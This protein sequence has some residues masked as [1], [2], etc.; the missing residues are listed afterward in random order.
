MAKTSN[1][2]KQKLQSILRERGLGQYANFVV[3]D[4][5][6]NIHAPLWAVAAVIDDETPDHLRDQAATIVALGIMQE[7][8]RHHLMG[9]AVRAR[10]PLADEITKPSKK[11]A[12]KKKAK[13]EKKSKK[14]KSGEKADKIRELFAKKE[15]MGLTHR[16]I[17]ELVGTSEGYVHAVIQRQRKA[18]KA[19]YGQ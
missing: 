3:E 17:A 1:S 11:K 18:Q 12:K 7:E 9:G 8:M 4:L 16:Q 14:K 19:A 10:P 5:A 15:E 2:Y 6:R 13:S